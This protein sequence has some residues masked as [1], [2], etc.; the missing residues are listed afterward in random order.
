[1][2][3]KEIIT[4]E[5]IK[6]I[7]SEYLVDSKINESI[8]ELKI[9]TL[10]THEFLER[11]TESIFSEIIYDFQNNKILNAHNIL[12]EWNKVYLE[13]LL[14][15]DDDLGE[16]AID[17]NKYY[18]NYKNIE[19]ILRNTSF[20]PYLVM[21]LI[22][23]DEY[24]SLKFYNLL[25]F[26]EL[27][28]DITKK[29]EIYK[30]TKTISVDGK[31]PTTF[32]FVTLKKQIRKLLGITPD[33]LFEMKVFLKGRLQ[34]TKDILKEGELEIKLITNGYIERVYKLEIEE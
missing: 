13:L 3:L 14:S 19:F 8:L 9:K 31:I 10:N 25:D 34:Y 7:I 21:L 12:K 20:F 23:K 32:D 27:E 4:K 28:F 11:K 2:K 24:K 5:Q 16:L 33:K 6:K 18:A 29:S 15:E 22:P 1:M 26:Q 17:L 30:D